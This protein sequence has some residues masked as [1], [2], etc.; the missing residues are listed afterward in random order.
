MDMLRAF[1]CPLK[2]IGH[3]I[4]D[5]RYNSWSPSLCKT[6]LHLH[7]EILITIFYLL[8]KILEK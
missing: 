2:L 6:L 8:G 4:T 5:E 1:M 7:R 3:L